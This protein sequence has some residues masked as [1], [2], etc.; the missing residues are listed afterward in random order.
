[1]RKSFK[2]YFYDNGLRNAIINHF[3]PINLRQDIGQLWENFFI[4]ERRKF[5]RNTALNPNCYFWRTLAQ[6]EVD[7]LEERNG[8]LSA[9][10]CK[11][12]IKQKG[13][14]SRAF[15]SAYPESIAHV[16]HPDNFENYLL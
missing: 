1:M 11:W 7:Y 14:V 12:S 10:E 5:I 6:Q 8:Q 2:I 4:S 13:K 9:F 3:N 15:L 16:V